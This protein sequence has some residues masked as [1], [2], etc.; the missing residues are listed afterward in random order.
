MTIPDYQTLMRPVLASLA[1]GEVRRSRDVIDSMAD[2]FNLTPEE[3]T[4]KVPSGQK[5]IDN[6]AGWALSYLSQAGLIERPGRGLVRISDEGRAALDQYPQ[7]IDTKALE[8]YPAFL[9]FRD[10]KRGRSATDDDGDQKSASNDE[11]FS[12]PNDL[13]ERAERINRAAV[14]REV[15]AA[16][17]KLTP[18]GFEELVIRLLDRMGYG[19]KGSAHRTAPTADGGI[20]GIIS[21]DPLGLDRIYVQA[22][23]YTDAPV[24]RPAIHGFAG[25]LLSQQGDRGVFITTSRFTRGAIDEAERINARIELID[26]ARLAELLVEHG[27]GVQPEQSVTL[28]RLDED[29]FDSI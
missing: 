23:R 14:E 7:R 21:Q 20:D 5:R 17:L 10:R 19:R 16:A 18:T 24:D 28:Y 15:L 12:T 1:N 27:V 11:E 29:F 2:E 9:E 3:R 26:G 25:A 8:A 22:K 4:A 13:A 6:R